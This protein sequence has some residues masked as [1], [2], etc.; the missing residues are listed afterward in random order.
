MLPRFTPAKLKQQTSP[1]DDPAW[2]FELKYDGF[3]ALA[4]I[5][6][7]EAELV[8]RKNHAYKSFPNLCADLA[9]LRHE[10]ILDGEIVCL[11]AEGRPVF[12]ELLFR[13]CEPYYYAF[14]CLWLDGEDVRTL[15][16]M[17]RKRI[18]KRIVPQKNSRLLFVRH[19]LRRGVNLFRLVCESDLEGIVAKRKESA[20][21]ED[22]IKVKNPDYSQAKGRRERFEVIR[23]KP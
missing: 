3:R 1:F 13:R 2:L 12:D 4:Y 9:R 22:W 21:G 7:G 17:D 6:D 11:D 20:Y 19:H 16:L 10:A 15:R 14:D 8:S 18:L 23:R 5:S